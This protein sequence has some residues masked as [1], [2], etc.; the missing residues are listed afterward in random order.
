M[1]ILSLKCV[2]CGAGLEVKPDIC[3]FSCG[4][5]GVQQ[6]VERGGGIVSLRRVEEALDDVKLGTNRTASELAIA[7]LHADIAAIYAQRDSA[8]S[9]LRAADHKNNVFIG[10]G[11]IFL[12]ALSMGILGPWGIPVILLGAFFGSRFIKSVAKEVKAVKANAEAKSAPLKAQ[13]VRHQSMIDSYDL[14]TP[15]EGNG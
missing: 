14:G 7:R 6:H 4:Y 11:F 5:C 1:K 10:W 2:N 3:D 9:A 8:L 12:V 13:I 15:V